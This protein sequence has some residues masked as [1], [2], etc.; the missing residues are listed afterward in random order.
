MWKVDVE[1][2]SDVI[3]FHSQYISMY[4]IGLLCTEHE[5]YYIQVQT[6]SIGESLV[7]K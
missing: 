7:A 6:I 5:I 2:V 4:E 1:C 3:G